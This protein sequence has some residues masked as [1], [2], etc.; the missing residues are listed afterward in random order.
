MRIAILDSAEIIFAESGFA[1][2]R[3]RDIAA[4]SEVNQA[5]INYYFQSKQQLF[6]QVFRRHGVM[7][8][9]QREKLLDALLA[10]D[11]QP[12]VTDLVAAYLKPQWDMKYSGPR[13]AAFVKLQARLHAEPEEQAIRLRREVYDRSTKRYLQAL[14]LALPHLP[15]RTVSLRMAFMIGTYLFMLNDLGRID[16]LS[17]NRVSEVGKTEMMDNLV[18]FLSAGMQAP[19]DNSTR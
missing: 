16:D 1:G 10:D 15:E 18:L 12:T 7:I 13:G 11:R 17:D 2:A 3:L 5:L 8:T 4:R 9:E 19:I 6:D 14:C